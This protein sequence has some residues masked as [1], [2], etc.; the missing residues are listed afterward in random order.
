MINMEKPR[1][2]YDKYF[3]TIQSVHASSLNG[4]SSESTAMRENTSNNNL[5]RNVTICDKVI[6]ALKNREFDS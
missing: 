4:R 2:Q 5:M 6:M 1:S 3:I